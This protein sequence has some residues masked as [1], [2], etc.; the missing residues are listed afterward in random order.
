MNLTCWS[1]TK[2]FH[3]ALCGLKIWC[4]M[5]YNHGWFW[6]RRP[7]EESISQRKWNKALFNHSSTYPQCLITMGSLKVVPQNI[8][9]PFISINN[10]TQGCVKNGGIVWSLVVDPDSAEKQTQ[11][12]TGSCQQVVFLR[13]LTKYG[14]Q[15]AVWD[16][17]SKSGFC[18]QF[19][20][21][22]TSPAP[23]SLAVGLNTTLPSV[24]SP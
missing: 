4:V 21:H 18:A 17:H 14:E 5:T 24:A 2:T 3:C 20:A 23:L 19:C 9:I 13:L 22:K 10:I 8:S 16:N 6:S 11:A 1:S 12:L 7:T 15:I